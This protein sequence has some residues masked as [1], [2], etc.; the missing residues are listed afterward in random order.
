MLPAPLRGRRRQLLVCSVG[1][2][3]VLLL[4]GVKCSRGTLL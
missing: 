2:G 3:S 4:L 1:S